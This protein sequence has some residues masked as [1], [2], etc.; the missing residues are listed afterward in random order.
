M[1]LWRWAAQHQQHIV[2]LLLLLLAAAGS[3]LTLHGKLLLLQLPVLYGS[4]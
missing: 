2:V 1:Q 3:M 4:N